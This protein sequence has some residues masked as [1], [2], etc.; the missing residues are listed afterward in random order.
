MMTSVIIFCKRIDK[1]G[2]EVTNQTF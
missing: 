2:L 1:I